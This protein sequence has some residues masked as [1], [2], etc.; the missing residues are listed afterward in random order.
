M[1][2]RVKGYLLLE[3][4][5]VFPSQRHQSGM[6][7]R[8][9]K[10]RTDH[11]LTVFLRRTLRAGSSCSSGSLSSTRI[12]SFAANFERDGPPKLGCAEDLR[13]LGLKPIVTQ[14]FMMQG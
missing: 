3:R 13:L 5:D 4:R 12:S 9:P 6:H 2:K 8:E 7:V 11:G 14:G 1:M 10:D